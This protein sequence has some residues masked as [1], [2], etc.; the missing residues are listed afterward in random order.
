MWYQITDE[1]VELTSDPQFDNIE[2]FTQF[3]KFL[4]R[5]INQLKFVQIADNCSRHYQDINEAIEFL[6]QVESENLKGAKESQAAI[7]YCK[8]AQ[9]EKM[10]NQGNPDCFDV[11][12]EVEN[13]LKSLVDVDQCV[14]AYLYKV[15]ALYYKRKDE[16]HHSEF[17]QN[18]I[19]YLAY[20]ENLTEQEQKEW[21]VSMG[22]AVL[23]GKEIYDIAELCEKDILR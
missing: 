15:K 1:L 20:E 17:Y 22:F 11:L 13:S 3:I 4:D 5:K 14:Y 8:V 19:Q 16:G 7:L 6:K 2:L 9:A 12:L 18:G 21:A 23:L 10:L